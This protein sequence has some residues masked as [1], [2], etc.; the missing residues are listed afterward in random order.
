MCPQSTQH[1]HGVQAS[2]VLELEGF[3]GKHSNGMIRAEHVFANKITGFHL[4][5]ELLSRN[6]LVHKM[7]RT[8]LADGSMSPTE[9]E[10]AEHT[11]SAPLQPRI[12]SMIE[13]IF[14]N[15]FDHARAYF[16]APSNLLDP[17]QLHTDGSL[18]TLCISLGREVI[19]V[20][21]LQEPVKSVALRLRPGDVLHLTGAKFQAWYG[22]AQVAS[23]SLS[24]SNSGG[25]RLDLVVKG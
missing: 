23:S 14:P 9:H 16:S 11:S 22:V 6:P 3:P 1:V 12:K 5:P 21:A 4:Y 7:L 8:I 15:Q 18:N 24:S 17:K 10:G 19:C 20:L 13:S 25:T 2:A